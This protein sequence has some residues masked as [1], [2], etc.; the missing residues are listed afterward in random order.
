MQVRLEKRFSQ[1]LAASLSY[2]WSKLMEATSYRNS[3]D[4]LPEE[5]I[6]SADRT[7]RTALT[8]IYELPF[9]R[10]KRLGN[11][12]NHVIS[13]LIGG[14]QAQAIYTAQS[15]A[16]LGF[17]NAIFL[18]NL[19]NV[20][21]SAGQRDPARWFNIASGFERDSAKQL[22]SNIQ[23][24]STRFGG[25]RADGPNNW[26]LSL[27][28]NTTIK[29]SVRLQFRAEAINALNHPQFTAPNTSPT[30]TA[31]GVVTGEF[32]WPRVVQFGLKA[33]F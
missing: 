1:G 17:G 23:T 6:S 5:V 14:W 18:G 11:T 7:Q 32:A 4:I 27:L 22:G 28:K 20:P 9:G 33:L 10:G 24:L 26:D 15:G 21:L 19:A 2:T 8:L 13:R 29:E 12:S 16:P 25:I 30:S 31:F 3:T